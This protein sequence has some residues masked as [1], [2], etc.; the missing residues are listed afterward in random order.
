MKF[1]IE[2]VT[3]TSKAGKP[4][5]HVN[6]CEYHHDHFLCAMTVLK[7]YLEKTRSIRGYERKL[8]LSYVPFPTKQWNQKQ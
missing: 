7:A 1:I 3:K 2:T 5:T 4:H 8:F 6:L